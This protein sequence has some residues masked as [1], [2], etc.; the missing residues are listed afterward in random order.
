MAVEEA[1][2]TVI[3]QDGIFELRQ[4]E[5]YVIAETIVTGD[6]TEAGNEAFQRLFRYISGNN[7]KSEKIPMTAPVVQEPKGKKIAMTAPVVQEA[8]SN[9]WSIAFV[10]PAGSTL[11]TLPEPA[12]PSVRL[13]AVPGRRVAAVRYSGR[14]TQSL[15]DNH[16]RQLRDWMAK[17]QL[18]ATG[19]ENWARYNPP[20]MPWFWR[21]NEII[22]VVAGPSN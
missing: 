16:A 15:Y 17:K 19:P 21:R 9:A 2:Y 5:P 7:R 11:E 4:Y 22:V 3:E 8:T 10:M 14:W 1:K 12:D 13:R 18:T 20:M 6:F